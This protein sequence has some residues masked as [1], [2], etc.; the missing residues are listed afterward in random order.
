[1][2][3]LLKEVPENWPLDPNSGDPLRYVY[4]TCCTTL[5]D[6]V[7]KPHPIHTIDRVAGEIIFL[8]KVAEAVAHGSRLGSPFFHLSRSSRGAWR[9]AELGQ[10]FRNEKP[11]DQIFTKVNLWGMYEDGVIT[12]DNFIDIST[13]SAI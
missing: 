6:L 12:A 13:T 11:K 3:L 1:M 7:F 4:H 10:R 8:T 9:F 5:D 2:E